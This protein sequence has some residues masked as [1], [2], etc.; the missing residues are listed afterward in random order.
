MKV[1]TLNVAASVSFSIFTI[2]ISGCTQTQ[3]KNIGNDTS[4]H[5]YIPS[6]NVHVTK[7]HSYQDG[8]ELVVYG[9]VKRNYN[10]CCEDAR[11]HV[12]IVVLDSDGFI[13]D[14]ASTF[15]HPRNIPKTRTRSS[16]FKVRLPITLPEGVVIRAAYHDTL[17]FAKF[18]SSNRTFQCQLNMAIPDLQPDTSTESNLL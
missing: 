16:S 11:G 3:I 10:F 8:T 5:Q 4:V 1:K 18:T 7:V 12:D 9:K 2:V 17:E 14:A 15:Y 6:Q 13:L